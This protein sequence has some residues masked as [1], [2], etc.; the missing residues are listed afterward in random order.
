MKEE[1]QPRTPFPEKSYF[2]IE[3]IV[4]QRD[5]NLEKLSTVSLPCKKKKKNVRRS[6][7]KRNL[8]LGHKLG[9]T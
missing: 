7:G 5:K 3:Q 9:S 8:S 4:F 2:K 6:L 1:C